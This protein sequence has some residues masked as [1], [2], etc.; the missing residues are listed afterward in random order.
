M[1]ELRG[2]GKEERMGWA[3][4]CLEKVKRKWEE[5]G[6]AVGDLQRAVERLKGWLVALRAKGGLEE[7]KEG[8]VV[9]RDKK[10]GGVVVEQP[11][12]NGGGGKNRDF[13]L[14]E[15]TFGAP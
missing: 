15:G 3:A 4:A 10:E 9:V 13:R 7:K 2:K 6:K 12:E 8:V 1:E 5:K 11:E 14:A